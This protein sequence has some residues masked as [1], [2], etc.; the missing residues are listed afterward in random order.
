MLFFHK[1]G[2]KDKKDLWRNIL[3]IFDF[4]AFAL[5]ISCILAKKDNSWNDING[6]FSKS[7]NIITPSVPQT[8]QWQTMKSQIMETHERSTIDRWEWKV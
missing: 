4:T 3:D 7:T 2:L 8:G 5:E 6:K 1:M